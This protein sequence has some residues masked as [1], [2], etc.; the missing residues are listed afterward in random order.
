[1]SLKRYRNAII[2]FLIIYLLFTIPFIP[3]NYLADGGA[4]RMTPILPFN[5]LILQIMAIVLLVPLGGI[6]GGFLPGYLFAPLMLLFY[7]KT[8]GFRMEFGIQHREKPEKFKNIWKGIFP[9]LLAVNFA[10]LLGIS[11]FAY[12]F[13]VSPSYLG[14]GEGEN[15]WPIVGFASLIPYM[16]AISMGIF[17]PVWFLLD[18]GIVFT[19]KQKVKDTIEPIEVRS[20]GSWYHYLLKGYAGI[21]VVFSYIFFLMDVL[22]RYNDPTNPGF[23]IAA[24]MLPIMPILITI[25]IIPVMILLEVYL[26]PRREFMRNFAKRLGIEGPLERPL[27]FN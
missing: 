1:M 24:I 19:N 3:L 8:I 16:T 26:K 12:N 6:I 11:D 14:G 13:V 18:A 5:T 4:D 15:L 10:L 2:I 21:G 23:I 17:S 27:N 22:S 9:A 25:L 20:M 7:K